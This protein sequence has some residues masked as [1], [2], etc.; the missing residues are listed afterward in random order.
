MARCEALVSIVAVAFGYHFTFSGL[1]PS[2]SDDDCS[3]NNNLRLPS[4]YMS[5]NLTKKN[6]SLYI[7][8]AILLIIINR[9]IMPLLIWYND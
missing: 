6:L 1:K 7:I 9:Y 2:R 3:F 8:M 4:Y 5:I